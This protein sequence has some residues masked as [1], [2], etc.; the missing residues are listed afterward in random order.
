MNKIKIITLLLICFSC[1]S[2]KNK[3]TEINDTQKQSELSKDA[4]TSISNGKIIYNEMCVVCHMKGGEGVPKIFPPLANS[5]YLKNNQELS[6]I[7]V[8]KGMSGKMIVNDITYNSVMSPLGLTNKEV[9]DVMNY[10]NNSWGNTY[11]EI[12]TSEDVTK[13]IKKQL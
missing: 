13:V 6:I 12:I 11:G 2:E 4:Q 9:A 8:K 3:N 1:S 5:D 7:G 10:I